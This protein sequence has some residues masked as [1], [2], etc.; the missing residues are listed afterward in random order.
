MLALISPAKRLDLDPAGHDLPCT[1]P[2]LLDEASQ[3]VAACK[4]LTPPDLQDLMGISQNLAELNFKRFQSFARPFGRENAKPA[5]LTF[6]GDTY[7]GL[8]A[9]TFDKEDWNYAQDH[10]GILSGLYGLLRPLDWIQPYR[11][12]MGSSLS[13]PR[14]SG[15]YSFWREKVTALVDR[16]TEGH[17]D[18]RVINLASKEYIK[19]VDAAS[20]SHSGISISFKEIREGKARVIGLF[21]KLARGTMARYLIR[22]RLERA[23]QL[24]DYCEDGYA[25]R[26]DLSTEVEW[27]FTR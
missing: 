26:P 25:Y 9:P 14:G 8:D 18:R 15:L 21:T 11:L 2:A 12:E 24:Q 10:L 13:T 4:E 7:R 6:A 19:A 16:R 1:Q 22:N 17:A 23:E 5:G 3:L 20:L 27:V